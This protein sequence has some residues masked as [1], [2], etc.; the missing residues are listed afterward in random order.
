METDSITLQLKIIPI[1]KSNNVI[2]S[3]GFLLYLNLNLIKKY[4]KIN[5]FV[6]L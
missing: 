5:V 2:V 4:E 3:W 6:V 1:I